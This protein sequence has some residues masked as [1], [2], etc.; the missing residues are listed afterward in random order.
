MSDDSLL[1]QRILQGDTSAYE[2]IVRCYQQRLFNTMV[3]ILGSKEDAEDVVQESF[4]QAYLKLGTFQG[5]SAFYTW[6]YRISFNIAISHR[7]RRK[8]VHSIDQ[9]REDVGNEPVDRSEGPGHRME[10]QENIRQVHTALEKLSE[11]HRDVL[12]LRELE[13]MDYDRIAEVLDLPVGTVRSRLHRARSH[14]KECLE[15]MIAQ[16]ERGLP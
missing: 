1:I 15:V 10:Q 3:H 5:N 9:V 12:V 14:L 16:S 11:E 8:K 7:R 2:E 13:G 4:V 6:L